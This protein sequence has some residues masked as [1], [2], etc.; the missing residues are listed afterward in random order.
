MA[1]RGTRSRKEVGDL[2]VPNGR[3]FQTITANASRR[4]RKASPLI[5]FIARGSS[6]VSSLNTLTASGTNTDAK[7]TEDVF[8]LSPA[9][10]TNHSGS[11]QKRRVANATESE[12]RLGK[13]D[14]TESVLHHLCCLA[15]GRL[16]PVCIRSQ[17]ERR[18]GM[19]KSASDSAHGYPR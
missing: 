8:V 1:R 7:S 2:N 17:G 5:F 11:L 4:T 16:K 3:L 12:H 10:M 15:I 19:A 9:W 18:V 14:P 6:L 13:F